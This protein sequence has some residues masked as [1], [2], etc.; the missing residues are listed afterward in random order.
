MRLGQHGGGGG[1]VAGHLVGLRG[2]LLDELGAE[3]L[4]GV[5]QGD[6]FGHGDA[7]FGDFR[8]APALVQHRVAAARAQRTRDGSGQLAHAGGQRL[9]SFVFIH[10]LFCH[11]GF[12]PVAGFPQVR[13][14]TTTTIGSRLQFPR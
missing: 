9:P 14:H 5:V 12:P 13:R 4:V 1:A 6:F 2:R 3:V 10:H 8:G 11:S 7:V